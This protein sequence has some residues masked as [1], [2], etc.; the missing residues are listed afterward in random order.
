[1]NW[2]AIKKLITPLLAKLMFTDAIPKPAKEAY[3]R[4]SFLEDVHSFTLVGGHHVLQLDF[5]VLH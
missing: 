2:H 5:K 3:K 1:M 4:M